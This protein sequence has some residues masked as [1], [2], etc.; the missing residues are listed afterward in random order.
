MIDASDTRFPIGQFLAMFVPVALVAIV[1]AFAFRQLSIESQFEQ[2]SAAERSHLQQLSGFV[3]AEVSFSVH[4]LNALTREAN[5]QHTMDSSSPRANKVLQSVFLTLA[6]RNPTYQ[7]IRWIDESG[8]ER[9]RV[10]RSENA[11]FIVKPQQH[12]NESA[13]Y[14][15]KNAASLNDREIYISRLDFN[16]ENGQSQQPLQPTI[17]VA[18]PIRN[19]KR[20]RRGIIIIDIAAPYLL[21]ALKIAHEAT[22][23]TDY[24]VVSE[25]GYG[26]APNARANLVKNQ[27]WRICEILHSTSH[28]VET[29]FF[30]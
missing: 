4:Q 23:D 16:V 18:K 9:V 24:I 12:R 7:Q 8:E 17:R 19:S 26:L 14:H 15:F 29:Y 1:V 28:C 11:P 3:A 2:I 20:K 22:P 6:N 10:M 25:D 27:R 5:V 21:E 13:N 30:K